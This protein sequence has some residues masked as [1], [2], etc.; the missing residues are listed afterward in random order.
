[1]ATVHTL[2]PHGLSAGDDII[3]INTG[4]PNLDGEYTVASVPDANH[5]TYAVANTGALK[6]SGNEKFAF[7]RVYT[8]SGLSA[9]AAGR[10]DGNLTLPCRAVRLAITAAGAG[11]WRL[12]VTLGH[13]R[14]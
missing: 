8:W 4:D 6:G 13:G 7:N 11:T 3:A 2:L 5:L 9:V 10:A 12:S 14:G 1:M